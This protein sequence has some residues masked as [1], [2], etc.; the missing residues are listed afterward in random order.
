MGRNLRILLPVALMAMAITALVLCPGPGLAEVPPPSG[1]ARIEAGAARIDITPGEPI[2]L[3]GYSGRSVPSEGIR[4]RLHAKALSFGGPRN[5]SVIV[6]V[7]ALG[8]PGWM[9][10]AL[11]ERL[12]GRIASSQ[13]AVCASHTHAAPYLRGFPPFMLGTPLTEAEQAVVDRYTDRLLD[14]LEGVVVEALEDRGPALVATGRGE[15]TFASNRRVLVDGKWAG[16]GTQPDGPVDH[17][18]PIL[19]ITGPEGSLRAVLVSYACHCTTT[20]GGSN[21]IHGDWAGFAQK[22]IERR[23]PGAIALVAIGCGADQNPDPRGE[24]AM[25][26]D[27]G[28]SI[29]D[30]V[31]RLLR[32][33]LHPLQTEPR[34]HQARIELPLDPLPGAGIWES[35]A[36]AKGS[37]GQFARVIL[38]RLENGEE[39]PRTVPYRIQT[40]TFGSD[41][42]ML[43]LAGE[44]VVDYARRFQREFDRE[45]LWITAYSNDVPCY[46]P[47][48]RMY[49]EGGYEVDRSMIYY[50]QPARLAIGTEKL[51]ADE[52]HRQ[53]PAAFRPRDESR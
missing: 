19:R 20:G 13:L 4:Q 51:I 34:G 42:A 41:L 48:R 28:A 29:A 46:I 26:R 16:F 53:L 9:T 21:E 14:K 47:S 32:S 33:E 10:D 15:V 43:F 24:L 36:A 7:D 5:P 30:E 37:E 45:R 25:A 50:G 2:R 17:A 23:H 39:L 49:A 8:I 27:H 35:K 11:A 22:E 12:E 31:D 6:T 3:S 38:D 18:L 40:W 1:S 44:V 52:V